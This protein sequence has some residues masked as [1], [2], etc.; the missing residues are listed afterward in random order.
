MVKKEILLYDNGNEL[1]EESE[2]VA[3]ILGA[4]RYEITNYLGNV[5]AVITDRKVYAAPSN[6]IAIYEAVVVLKADYYPFGMTMP[7]RHESGEGYRFGYNGMPSDDEISGDKNSYDYGAR[8]YNP[9]IG[10]W[11]S[12]D[13]QQDR[14]PSLT[15]Y[16]YG[17]NC[18]TVFN[19]PDGEFERR[20][21]IYKDKSG[22]VVLTVVTVDY[23][24][25]KTDH[26]TH[27]NYGLGYSLGGRDVYYYDYDVTE[28]K[29]WNGNEFVL[30]SYKEEITGTIIRE[31]D[32]KT[33]SNS[34]HRKLPI[35]KGRTY[36]FGLLFNWG[37]NGTSL[38]KAKY[39][40]SMD[41]DLY[42]ALEKSF[43]K[44]SKYQGENPIDL[45]GLKNKDPKAIL[46]LAKYLAEN[47]KNVADI[48]EMVQ[49]I[50]NYQD[51]SAETWAKI[52]RQNL[53]FS[54]K[55]KVYNWGDRGSGV[56]TKY[57]YSGT[58]FK[59]S[60]DGSFLYSSKKIVMIP[61]GQ[62]AYKSGTK[63]NVW[64]TKDKKEK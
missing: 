33:S 39:V 3:N 26:E 57:G 58:E 24:M 20:T 28:I 1:P 54:S 62:E 14:T 18:P 15:P 25:V 9:R 44:K 63:D 10:R 55:I 35:E 16:R 51:V 19:D 23:T 48:Y 53:D 64:L 43:T 61:K 36:T 52:K 11:L 56:I 47:S 4:K 8:I 38:D 13:P 50:D 60:E 29:Q 31:R 37:S 27:T 45:N 5:N 7:G 32:F 17:F 49:S 30:M 22:K 46:E 42:N 34:T 2:F 12:I 59:L 21:T 41:Q 6:T 40:K